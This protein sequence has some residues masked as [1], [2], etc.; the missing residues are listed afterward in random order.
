MTSSLLLPLVALAAVKVAPP[1][2]PATGSQTSILTLDAPAMVR[3]LAQSGPGTACTVVDKVRGPFQSSGQVGKGGCD[4]DLLLDAGSYKLR[5]ESPQRGKGTVAI[6]ARPFPE[7]NPKP[8]RLEKGRRLEQ[9]L[10]SGEQASFWLSLR[11]REVPFLHILGK[12]A[13][14]VR[15][16]KNGEWLEPVSFA[17]TTFSAGPS[18]AVHEWRFDEMLEPGDYLVTAY[19]TSVLGGSSGEATDALT[20]EYGFEPLPPEG[21]VAFTLP[22]TGTLAFQ[23]ERG[24]GA[25]LASLD[26]PP[27][28]P[29]E[30][31]ATDLLSPSYLGMKATPEHPLP[32]ERGLFSAAR[33]TLE[34]KRLVPQAS[35]AVENDE[36][37]V[38]TLRGAPGTRGLLQW[39]PAPRTNTWEGGY[40]GAAVRSISFNVAAAGDYLIGLH[41]LPADTD[42]A[43]LGCQLEQKNAKSVEVLGRDVLTI[44]AGQQ[45]SRQ[46]NYDGKNAIIWFEVTR[47]DR[48]RILTLGDRKNRCEVSRVDT[49]G[50]LSRLTQTKPDAK[51]CMETLQL[52]AGVYQLSLYDGLSGVEKLVVREDSQREL[53]PVPAKAGCLIVAKQLAAGPYNLAVSRGGDLAARGLVMQALPLAPTTPLH[54]VLDPGRSLALPVAPAAGWLARSAA[55][56]SFECDGK[57]VSGQCALHAGTLTL[58]NPLDEVVSLTLLRPAE[59]KP[60]PPLVAFD[61]KAAPLPR[62]VL[63]QPVYLDFERGQSHSLVFEVDR[64]GLYNVTTLGLLST[65]C[66][67]RTPVVPDVAKDAGSGRGR[68]CL[69][70]GYLRPGRYLLTATTIGPSR[71]RGGLVMTRRLPREYAA[72]GSDGETFF[73]VDAGELAQQ[74]LSVQKGGELQLSTTSQGP[75]LR[76]RLDDADGWPLLMVPTSCSQTRRFASG[77]YLWTQLPL[78]VESMRHTKLERVREP[79]V[80]QGNKAHSIE[81][82]TFYNAQLGSSGKDEFLFKLEGETTVE[83][84]LTGGMQGHIYMLTPGQPPRPMEVIPPQ[85]A[86]RSSEGDGEAHESEGDEGGGDGGSE[87]RSEGR[88]EGEGDG[89]GGDY[90]PPPPPPPRPGLLQARAAPPLPPGTRVTLPRGQYKLVAEHSRGD[91]GIQYKLHLGSAVLL[92]GMT[93]E[94]PTPVV[95]PVHMPR[96][97]TLRLRTEGEADLLCRLFDGD[98]LV[99]E[100]SENAADWNCALAE[101]L[102]AGNYRLV[103]E[104]KTQRPGQTRLAL[105]L[106][107]VEDGGLVKDGATR[108]LAAAVQ[109]VGLPV[110]S[111]T[112][113][114][115]VYE[116]GFRAKSAFSCALEDGRGQVVHKKTRV[117]ECELLVRPQTERFKV[118]LWTTDGTTQVQESL[119]SKPVRAGGRGTLPAAQASLVTIPRAGRYATAPQVYCLGGE[120]RGLLR[121]CGPQT[122]LPAG[123]TVFATYGAKD[124]QLPLDEQLVTAG[125]ATTLPLTLSAQPWLQGLTAAKSTVFLLTAEVPH[126]ERAAPACAFETGVRESHERACFAAS[127]VGTAAIA[128]AWAPTPGAAAPIGA[129]LTHRAVV[130]PTQATALQLGRTRLALASQGSLFTLPGNQRARLELTLPGD[131]WAVLL[132][133]GGRALE[134][135]APAA[136]P[137]MLSRCVVAGRGGKLLIS[138]SDSQADVTTV[139]LDAPERELAL[140]SLGLFEDAPRAPGSLRLRVPAA[141]TERVAVVEGEV[142]CTFIFADGTR[143]SSCQAAVPSGVAVELKLEH[144]PSSLRVMVYAAG[145]DRWT[146]LGRTLPAQAGA[147]LPAAVAVPLAGPAGAAGGIDR[148]LVLTKDAVVRVAADS[149]V[150]GLL[151]GGE[152]LAVD[153]FDAGCELLRLLPAGSYRVVV[154][155][156]ATQPLPG[157]LRWTAE[158]VSMLG[159]GVGPEDWVAPAE[160]RVYRFSTGSKGWVGLGVQ[161][162]SESLSC[163]IYDAGHRLLGDGCQQ[164]LNL[165]QGSYLLMIRLPRRDGA[166]PLRFR[167]VLL[168]LAGA[169][170]EVPQDYLKD[171]FRRIGVT[172]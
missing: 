140:S 91:V 135:C 95:V 26:S 94:L 38:V 34:P 164:Y 78:T 73:S 45:L 136:R 169:Q 172:P 149:G 47:S 50:A 132:D 75:A 30:L 131:A 160:V 58:K 86:P 52:T 118:R 77:S 27:T 41:D 17:H 87:G 29:F 60:L 144:G 25:F 64:A 42:S 63:D 19:G 138:S 108:T 107:A 109:T 129:Q 5:L 130:L 126:G 111:A 55:G 147:A 112:E 117:R 137:T 98:R 7:Q 171:L 102:L 92:P 114:D 6:T 122:S 15:L 70:S 100:S 4:V 152:L 97:G 146:R 157:T 40:Y 23:S 150:C 103:L 46:F 65:E 76:C 35:A 154:R 153:G 39:A 56:K 139:L 99:F 134:L 79:L 33:F 80:L 24:R 22:A 37:H 123:P 14:D 53:K 10:R 69:V 162:S 83:V 124:L 163:S 168:G 74:R 11:E 93:R 62:T 167:P 81:F 133:D 32:S 110:A 36:V 121:P 9:P 16:W 84:V 105:G 127:N 141:A 128:R 125:V 18:R 106:A 143:V 44:G 8:V 113:P 31:A 156:F 90:T 85:Q 21:A 48:Y 148:T 88:G 155:P 115:A 166:Q 28:T 151:R 158:P 51:S 159:D 142:R 61:P 3:L 72:V 2:V 71:G 12:N 119:H 66:R 59:P 170:A 120:A 82:H 165:E 54:L 67:L 89:E 68:N 101:P 104:S 161:T 13:G 43:P 57:P 1:S 96:D 116:L 20:V 145:R 49:H